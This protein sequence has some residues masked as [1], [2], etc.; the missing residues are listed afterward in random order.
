MLFFKSVFIVFAPLA[1]LAAVLGH[2]FQ[3][4]SRAI[5]MLVSA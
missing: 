1:A 5:G 4:F 3:S 2:N